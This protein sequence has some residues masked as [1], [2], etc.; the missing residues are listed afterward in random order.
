L[1][2]ADCDG[3]T[4][5]LVVIAKPEGGRAVTGNVIVALDREPDQIGSAEISIGFRLTVGPH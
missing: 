4:A 1:R 3:R 5:F 2:P